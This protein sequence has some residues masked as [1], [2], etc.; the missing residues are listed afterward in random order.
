MAKCLACSFV[1]WGLPHHDHVDNICAMPNYIRAKFEGGYYF[2]TVVTYER[3]EL[4]H[5]ELARL[6]LRE[7]IEKIRSRRPFETVAFCLLFEHLHCIWKLPE[8]DA[9]YSKRW[10]SIK[11]RFSRE[12]LNLTG[13]RKQVSSSRARKGEVCI[14]QRRFWEHQIRDEN[15]LQ[16]H[17]DYIH[18][19][20]VKHGLVQHV[21]DWTWSTYH[22][23]AKEGF[24]E[25]AND[26]K[27]ITNISTEGF[28]E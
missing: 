13:Q 11:G 12:Y 9:D 4:F 20:P 3:T 8:N 26:F 28:G 6:C 27:Q 15:D 24:Y 5:T 19:N 22:K 17:V 23:Y 25:R 1:G 10:S 2:F 21:E 7:A 18:Y 14:W 16:R